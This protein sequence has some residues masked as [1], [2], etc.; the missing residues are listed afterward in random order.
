MKLSYLKYTG[1]EVMEVEYHLEEQ[2]NP[3]EE[4]LIRL[5]EVLRMTGL[6]KSTMY[7]LMAEDRFPR[8]V[9]GANRVSL[10]SRREVIAWNRGRD[11]NPPGRW[12]KP[13]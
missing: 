7:R 9:Y 10:W 3:E 11:D 13:D 5:P 12:E 1:R 2:D 6:S 4:R 8:R